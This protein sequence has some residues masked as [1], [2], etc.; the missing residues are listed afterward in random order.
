[1]KDKVVAK[2]KKKNRKNY[3]KTKQRRKVLF[4]FMSISSIIYILWRF[5][6]TLPFDYGVLAMVCGLLLF[7]SELIAV[8]E[9][10][11]NQ[12]AFADSVVPDMPIISDDM[13]PEVDI[14]IATHTEEKE[15]LYK[16]VN[17]CKFLKYPDKNKINI[18]LCDDTNRPEIKSLADEMQINY[19]TILNNKHAKA[20]NLNNAINKTNS[21]L[22][23][24]LDADMIAKS[25]F[26][27]KTVPY[28]F[29][30]KYKK[31]KKGDFVLKEAHE[32]DELEKIGFVQTPQTFYNP[33]MFQFNL[34]AEKNIPNEQDYFFREVNVGKNATNSPIYAGSNTVISRE[35][36]NSIGGIRTGTITEDFATGM[37]IQAKGYTC[38]AIPDPL[39]SGL[40]PTTIESLI[41]QRVRWGR[42]CVQTL[43]R[44]KF[45]FSKIS[46]SAKLS[47]F[48]CLLYWTTFFRRTVYIFSPILYTV[49]GICLVN[50]NINEYL[51]I[52]L[53]TYLIYNI[54]LK[55]LSRGKI[56]FR[57][58]NT[59][60]TILAPYLV[61]PIL[62]E[63]FGIKLK[64]FNVTEKSNKVAKNTRFIYALPNIIFLS[65]SVIG[66]IFTLDSII[67]GGFY[68]NLI[69][70]YWLL[71][72]SYFL[73]M[74]IIFMLGRT[75]YRDSE[76]F[77][78]SIPVEIIEEN[79]T[80]NGTVVDISETGLSFTLDNPI[81]FNSKEK[82]VIKI[83]DR[84]YNAMLSAKIVHTVA[85]D[86][87]MFKYNLIVT[88]I[89][90]E[91]KK[92]YFG[93]IYDR[94]FVFA[95]T[96]KTKGIEDMLLFFKK[97]SQKTV[98][99]N[100]LLLRVVLDKKYKT[101]S[102]KS[103]YIYDFNGQYL[104]STQNI[105][106]VNVYIVDDV[107]ITARNTK[108]VVQGK[109]L[110]EIE[111]WESVVKKL[112]KKFN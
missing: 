12:N 95:T 10:I 77:E 31:N 25:D 35:A 98:T 92:E 55:K 20:G 110:Y 90:D 74:S 83:K 59:V 40:S 37:D 75:N 46:L 54:S 7:I 18:Y 8:V 73:F 103:F 69:I 106:S 100:R 21:P 3:S 85:I 78:V 36:L 53:P 104:S 28:F 14:L 9:G 80:Y 111:N 1:M 89:D 26:L 47:Y 34:F 81:F 5:F 44:P 48:A 102:G 50:L 105:S 99:S 109:Y 87:H 65:A 66:I 101:D 19:I 62:L 33:D 67:F 91:N 107:L 64:K 17:A 52:G 24:T 68:F 86:N 61:I 71:I 94:N 39:V 82:L 97:K 79:N 16:T 108:K 76:R 11:L 15:L 72:N 49:F 42:G 41:K 58:S 51:L 6:F 27:L 84:Q 96:I 2:Y 29:L 23:V 56:D 63:T 30:P 13:F 4:Y 88:D 22:I 45:F 93:L 43:L 112:K 60:D 38:I 32:I 70:L 57:W